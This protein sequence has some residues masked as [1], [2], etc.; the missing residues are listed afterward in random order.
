MSAT[1]TTTNYNLPIFIETDKPAW[2]VDFNGAMRTIDATLKNNADAIATKSPILTFNDTNEID[3][4]KTGDIVTAHLASGVSDKVGR[5]LVT[6]ISAP[7]SEQI[8]AI[9]TSGVQDALTIGNGLSVSNGSIMAIDLNLDIKGTATLSGFPTGMTLGTGEV[10]YA[11]NADRTVGKVYGSFNFT[12]TSS[13]TSARFNIDTGINVAAT[14]ED[15]YIDAA[16]FSLNYASS[17]YTGVNLYVNASG[18]VFIE[19]KAFPGTSAYI[20]LW[21]CIYFFKDFGDTPTP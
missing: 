1:N 11:L 21:P 16:G 20:Y 9:N 19:T 18:R 10:S 12:A 13:A 6:P 15:Y 7:A 5:A 8:V 14:G 3:F 2:L 4:T 17:N